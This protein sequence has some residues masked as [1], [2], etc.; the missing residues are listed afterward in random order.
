[1]IHHA[2]KKLKAAAGVVYKK[3]FTTDKSFPAQIR[4]K[5]TPKSL[6]ST[7]KAAG[8]QSNQRASAAAAW[9]LEF[10][11]SWDLLPMVWAGLYY[12]SV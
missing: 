1:M 4:S 2:L 12:E 8:V 10:S 5:L 9:L 3:T 11:G 7:Y 6:T